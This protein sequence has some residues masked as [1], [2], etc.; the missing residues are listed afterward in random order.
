M[1]KILLTALV[2][3]ASVCVASAQAPKAT[4]TSD[5]TVVKEA[6]QKVTDTKQAQE[7]QT[8]VTELKLTDEQQKKIADLNKAFSERR[9][10]VEN[11]T[12][13]SEEAKNERKAA[14]K[15]AQ[16][17]QFLQILT[18][19]QQARYKELVLAKA[20]ETPKKDK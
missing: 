14:M 9:Q 17:A 8:L 16:E 12:T 5:A 10:S 13:V 2:I 7:W 4:T 18:P 19:E 11:N 20:T 3:T 1:K 15:K 6:D